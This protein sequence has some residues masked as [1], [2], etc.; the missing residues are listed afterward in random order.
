MQAID[1]TIDKTGKLFTIPG[2]MHPKSDVDR[3]HIPRKDGGRGLIA[4]EDCVE[5]AVRGLEEYVH[6]SEG[7]LIQAARGVSVLW[8]SSGRAKL[9]LAS[10]WRLEKGDRKSDS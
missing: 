6:G 10:E 1:R 4:I 5:S 2:G 9:D 8:L 7:R 3:L